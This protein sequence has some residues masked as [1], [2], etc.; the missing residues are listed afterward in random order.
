MLLNE[1]KRA[2]PC[3]LITSSPTFGVPETSIID[4]PLKIKQQG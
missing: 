1:W 2:L 4:D 3:G